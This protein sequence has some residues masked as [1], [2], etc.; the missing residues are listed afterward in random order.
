MYVIICSLLILALVIARKESYAD[1]FA[2]MS[3]QDLRARRASSRDEYRQRYMTSFL[4]FTPEETEHLQTLVNEIASIEAPTKRFRTLPW[5]F[6]KVPSTIEQGF[7]HTLGNTIVLSPTFFEGSH[8]ANLQTLLH[9]KTHI[10][11][12]RFPKQTDEL[13]AAWGFAPTDVRVPSRNN[14]DVSGAY[15]KNNLIPVQVYTSDAPVAISDSKPKAYD[16]DTGT[17]R[18]I[19]ALDIPSYISQPEHPFEI[20]AILVPLVLL[21][22]P[23]DD[24]YYQTTKRWA[25]TEL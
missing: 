22:R 4:P 2:R 14:P 25:Q 15:M 24:F 21:K 9:E 5:N 17:F 12:R 3:P 23:H 6:A 7:P 8:E 10:F 1:Y 18:D 16:P 11:Q 19:A 20:M 13:I